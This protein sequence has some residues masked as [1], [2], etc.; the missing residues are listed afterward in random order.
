MITQSRLKELVIYDES[1]GIFTWRISRG[2]FVKQ[3]E[4]AGSL[5]NGYVSITVDAGRYRAHRLAWLYHYGSFPNGEIDHIDGNKSNN[6]IENLRDVSHAE[7]MQNIKSSPAATGLLGARWH[8][9]AK[10]W[11]SVISVNGKQIHLGY[12]STADEAHQS[13]ITA[14]RKHHPFSTL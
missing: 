7:N 3:G 4:T 13:Y 8:S 6:S 2:G 12:F 5:V 14:K 10:R 9:R 1:S 11:Q